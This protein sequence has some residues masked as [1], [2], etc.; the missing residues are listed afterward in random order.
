MPNGVARVPGGVDGWGGCPNGL[1]AL[2]FGEFEAT[3]ED[4]GGAVVPGSLVH[5]TATPMPATRAAS[6]ATNRRRAGSPLITEHP[7]PNAGVAIRAPT[8]L[9]R[10]RSGLDHAD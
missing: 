6:A 1:T 10:H 8:D 7:K 5:A 3:V 9:S 2:W 4:S